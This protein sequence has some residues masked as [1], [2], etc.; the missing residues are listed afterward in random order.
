MW[1]QPPTSREEKSHAS[2]RNEKEE[3]L[4]QARGRSS[5]GSGGTRGKLSGQIS[6]RSVEAT[7]NVG[8]E[9]NC[10]RVSEGLKN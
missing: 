10:G 1:N 3:E 5:L 9:H 2:Q 7:R 8:S 4:P 6:R